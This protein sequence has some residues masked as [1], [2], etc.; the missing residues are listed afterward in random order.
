MGA[1]HKAKQWN[2]LSDAQKYRAWSKMSPKRRA[3]AL[4]AMCPRDR[5]MI[6][7]AFAMASVRAHGAVPEGCSSAIIQAPARGP[8][9][10]VQEFTIHVDAE[11]VGHRIAQPYPGGRP[12]RIGDAFDRMEDQ[13]RRAGG[14]ALFEPYQVR[15]G[16]DYAA[17]VER[18]ESSGIKGISLEVMAQRG[19]GGGEFIDAV[20]ADSRA[21]AAMERRIGDGFA[22]P[23]RRVRPSA[24]GKR[25]GIRNLA[26]VQRVC[27][28]GQT[29]SEV[30]AACGWGAY[31]DA[32]VA[33]REALCSCLDRM[34][35]AA[36]T[37]G[38]GHK[39]QKR[40]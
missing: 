4:D 37:Y 22:I 9:V 16:R 30:L 6:E 34:A 29:V 15:A 32:R 26:L 38:D 39:M 18:C 10:A 14:G 23:I 17:L 2:D 3:L 35:G 13:A 21:R 5:R 11:G 19:G 8:L 31:G 36:A 28:G 40:D 24:R 25:V 1:V 7:G 27:V 33:L 20:I 12:A